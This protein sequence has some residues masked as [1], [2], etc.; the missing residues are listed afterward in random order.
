ATNDQRNAAKYQDMLDDYWH[1]RE[2]EQV[3]IMEARQ[4][5]MKQQQ[6][7]FRL[8]SELKTAEMQAKMAGMRLDNAE[9]SLGYITG[10][11]DE[12]QSAAPLKPT[13][14]YDWLP[15]VNCYR[16]GQTPAEASMPEWFLWCPWSVHRGNHERHGDFLCSAQPSG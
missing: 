3:S 1:K 7:L 12:L 15:R 5:L 2:L 4:D 14:P 10:H 13:N 16:L 8:P 6:F 11:L 9:K